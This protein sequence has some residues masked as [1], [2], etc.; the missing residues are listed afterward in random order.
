MHLSG[1]MIIQILHCPHCHG[2]DIVRHGITRQEASNGTGAA[3]NAALVAHFC[4]IIATRGNRLRWSA[5]LSIWPSMRV[6]FVTPRV[7]CTSVRIRL[8]QN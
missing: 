5:R 3:S 7:F 2:M 4:W 8:W 6:A 1:I